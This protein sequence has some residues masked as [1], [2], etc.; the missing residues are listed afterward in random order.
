MSDASQ[1]RGRPP[2]WVV[3]V[4]VVVVALLL[5]GGTW[6][7]VRSSRTS[8]SATSPTTSTS[9][10]P[11]SPDQS[12]LEKVVLG[13]SDAPPTA[14]YAEGVLSD[15]TSLSGPNGVT[16][17]LCN[18]SFPSEKLRVARLQTAIVDNQNAQSQEVVST[19]GVLYRSPAATSEAF[20]EL[21]AAKANCPSGVVPGTDGQP[22]VQTTFGTPPDTN[23][24]TVAGVQR[25]AYFV[26]QTTPSTSPTTSGQSPSNPPTDADVV[27]LC[28]GRLFVGIYIYDP[29]V[30]Q[31]GVAGQTTVAG[32]VSVI[33][34]RMAQLPSSAT[35]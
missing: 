9:T 33:E 26:T 25:L 3:A 32:V 15:G 16:L 1:G 22:A 18:G 34:Q 31:P 4:V 11:V 29:Q 7:V 10:S 2:G 12:L 20:S 8:S 6:L 23:W 19:E 30:A 13:A 35:K 17:D 28:R 21:K 24:P 5:A 27:Y 14:G